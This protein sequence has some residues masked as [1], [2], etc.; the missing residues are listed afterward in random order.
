[1]VNEQVVGIVSQACEI[2]LYRVIDVSILQACDSRLMRVSWHV[3]K[4]HMK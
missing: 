2:V 1:M 4:V 3:Y